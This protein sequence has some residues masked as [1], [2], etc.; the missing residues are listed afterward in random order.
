MNTINLPGSKGWL[1]RKGGNL[2]AICEPIIKKMWE[3]RRLRT[4]WAF[5]ACYRDSF[6]FFTF[7]PLLLYAYPL[8]REH[9]YR[10]IAQKRLWYICLPRGRC[11]VTALHATVF[12][13][14]SG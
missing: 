12:R 4:L 13:V 1:T 8:P 10:A 11:I 9:V 3:P 7:L 2:T 5:T 6:T 14:I